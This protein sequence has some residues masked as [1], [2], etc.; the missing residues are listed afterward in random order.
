MAFRITVLLISLLLTSCSSLPRSDVSQTV[1]LA[2]LPTATAISPL[3]VGNNVWYDPGEAVWDLAQEAGVALYRIG[4]HAYDTKMPDPQKLLEWVL[5]AQERGA[6]V[7]LQASQYQTPAAAAEL[8]RFF[9]REA[10]GNKPLRYWSIGNEPWLQGGRPPISQVAPQVEAYFKPI[11]AAM[12]AVD[13]TILIYGIDECEYFDEEYEALFGGANDITGMVPGQ[14]YSY[15]DGLSF[16]RYPQGSGDPAT[17]GAADLESRII[18]AAAKARQ[19]DALRQKKGGGTFGWALTEYNSKGGY[20][21]HT[22]SNGQMFAQILGLSMKYQA[23]FTNTWSMSEGGGQRGSTDFGFVDGVGDTPRASYWHMQL[24]ARH[25][26]G[27]YLEGISTSP[28]VVVYGAKDAE[29]LSVMVLNRS[30]EALGYRLDMGA[31]VYQDRLPPRSTQVLVFPS[32]GPGAWF[33]E[34]IQ[35]TAADF[36][37]L[38]PPRKQTVFWP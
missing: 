5:L 27:V 23:A 1:S 8:V 13:P 30:D 32:E 25:F 21:V 10:H 7:M 17:E 3:L 12:K 22:F 29:R 36:E 9:N 2:L 15:C 6:E 34:K 28:L 38:A 26:A 16:H 14:D 19:I 37:E 4:G 33:V 20:E 35:Y 24:V 18:K 31:R 11:A